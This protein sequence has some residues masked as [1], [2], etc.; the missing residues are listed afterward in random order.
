MAFLAAFLSLIALL[1]LTDLRL[2][3]TE[4]IFVLSLWSLVTTLFPPKQRKIWMIWF[5]A[6]LL[7]IMAMSLAPTLSD[8]IFRYIWEGFLL[9]EG[10]NP[11]WESV[12]SSSVPH[13]SKSL[14][15][16]P[17]LTSIYP[18]GA[19]TVFLFLAR[20]FDNV[21]AVK[22][23]SVL[24]D[25]GIFWVLLQHL[26]IC[27]ATWIY[28]LHP[29][30]ILE[31]A[32]SGHMESWA[33][34][35]FLA[36]LAFPRFRIALLWMGGMIKLLPMILIPLQRISVRIWIILIAL[37][38][39]LLFSFS[40][41]SIPN[42]AQMYAKH[43]SFFGSFFPVIEFCVPYPRVLIFVLGSTVML[44]VWKT[45]KDISKQAFWLVSTFVLLSPTV[46]PWYLLWV[47]PLALW[48]QNRPWIILCML[49]PFWYVALTTWNEQTKSWSPP[50]WPQVF[51]YG[52]FLGMWVL[53]VFRARLPWHP[54]NV[55]GERKHL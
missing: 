26:G 23:L 14:V 53:D 8:D 52:V 37:T 42:G 1:H 34:L 49:Y 6:I 15:N 36:A 12:S 51:C 38:I 39:G 44:Y 46:H 48:H 30:P 45:E 47:F 25:L 32:S 29:L 10:G 35:P 7:R 9:S 16:H 27:K 13:W 24:C 33:I 21:W 11:Y 17:D 54:S 20:I 50:V 18:P 40:L 3:A 28:A 31:N 55:G 4:M 5:S 19:Q 41:F 2:H 22:T 43:W